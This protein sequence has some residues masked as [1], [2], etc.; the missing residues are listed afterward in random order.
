MLFITSCLKK[1]YYFF[2]NVGNLSWLLWNKV[3]N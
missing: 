1:R 3:M 2:R